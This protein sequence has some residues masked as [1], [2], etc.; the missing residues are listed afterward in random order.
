M[1]YFKSSIK[2][3]RKKSKLTQQDLANLVNVR[4]ETINHIENGRYNP[5]LKLAMDLSKVLGVPIESLFQYKDE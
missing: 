2:E 4:R 3:F 5:T 1:Y